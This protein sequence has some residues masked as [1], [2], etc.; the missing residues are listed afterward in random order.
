[1]SNL[2]TA[3]WAKLEAKWGR[4]A[5]NWNQLRRA[6]SHFLTLHLRLDHPIR[7]TVL[8]RFPLRREIPR[9]PDV[10]PAM[11]WRLL[12]QL[13]PHLRAPVVTLVATGLRKNE[14][15][16]LR[17]EDLMPE[18]CGLRVRKQTKTG[19]SIRVVYADPALWGWIEAAIPVS[20]TMDYILKRWRTVC[21]KEGVPTITFHD[22]RHCHGQWATDEGM[23]AS[24]IQ[25]QL[26]HAT[27]TQTAIYTARKN[28]RD[29]ASAVARQLGVPP[30][31]PPRL[32]VRDARG[33]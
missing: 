9:E 28:R 4:S 21:R 2:A 8:D 14:L 27:P 7:R 22:L 11:F 29:T 20:L 1:M 5:A 16:Q 24:S 19:S 15:G 17:R 6:V 12:S 33:A 25:K 18:T 30:E 32:E 23:D 10:S 26:G 13:S 31:V 3:D